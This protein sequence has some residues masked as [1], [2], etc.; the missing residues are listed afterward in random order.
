MSETE[1]PPKKRLNFITKLLAK[2]QALDK[3]QNGESRRT[4]R[5]THL[6]HNKTLEAQAHASVFNKCE[7]SKM[8]INIIQ[9]NDTQRSDNKI[10]N[11]INRE[12]PLNKKISV[13]Q[14]FYTPHTKHENKLE[15]KRSKSIMLTGL[16]KNKK[17]KQ[18]L[19]EYISNQRTNDKIYN[20]ILRNILVKG[21]KK[22]PEKNNLTASY[23]YTFDEQKFMKYN[24]IT[25]R[26]TNINFILDNLKKKYILTQNKPRHFLHKDKLQDTSK[27]TRSTACMSKAT[28]PKR[29]R[30]NSMVFNKLH[31]DSYMSR[32]LSP[33][34]TCK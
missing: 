16:I 31:R 19:R 24:F 23:G 14:H 15:L 7:F 20:S 4:S 27:Y 17:E 2:K 32:T 26:D 21:Y 22:L 6:F 9:S 34:K 30:P 12:V 11:F 28:S 1:N 29:S 10:Y 13:I 5:G 8:L 3:E 18:A 33:I 25:K